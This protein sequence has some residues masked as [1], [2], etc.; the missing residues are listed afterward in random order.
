MLAC[1]YHLHAGNY[2]SPP[3]ALVS[4]NQHEILAV[5]CPCPSVMH[6]RCKLLRS[7]FEN[8]ATRDRY[9]RSTVTDADPLSKTT[10]TQPS[11]PLQLWEVGCWFQPPSTSVQ[12]SRRW[13][14][15]TTT[16]RLAG[17]HLAVLQ[18]LHWPASDSLPHQSDAR[19]ERTERVAAVKAA[20]GL[21]VQD[22]T[23]HQTQPAADSAVLPLTTLSV[24]LQYQH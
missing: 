3:P 14:A 21:L 9:E 20:T 12:R 5:L 15:R 13:P 1:I 19:T 2:I 18:L 11:R 4:S 6:L 10:P 22:W 8:D 23:R 17:S 16:S 7:S 24:Q